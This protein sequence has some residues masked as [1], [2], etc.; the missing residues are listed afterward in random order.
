M[1]VACGGGC[2]PPRTCSLIGTIR[3]SLQSDQ[4]SRREHWWPPNHSRQQS[5]R[6]IGPNSTA[7]SGGW[8]KGNGVHITCETSRADGPGDAAIFDPNY[9][10]QRGRTD[11]EESW[12]P[13]RACG[14]G[15]RLP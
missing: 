4:D 8:S 15:A 2:S 14:R 10:G 12:L 6:A 7:P 1:S 3:P 5:T 13:S 9:A 11:H